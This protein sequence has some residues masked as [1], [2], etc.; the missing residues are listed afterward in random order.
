MN[1]LEE[2][3]PPELASDLYQPSVFVGIGRYLSVFSH[4]LV[5]VG[6]YRSVF[7]LFLGQYWSVFSPFQ[8]GRYFQFYL[9][10]VYVSMFHNHR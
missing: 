4:F 6:R 8:V 10:Q 2:E 1:G 5:G 7:S 9:P 3:R